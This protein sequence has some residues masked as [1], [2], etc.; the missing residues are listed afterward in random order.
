MRLDDSASPRAVVQSRQV[1]S[2]RGLPLDRPDGGP[3]PVFGIVH[4]GRVEYRLATAAYVGRRARI[5]YVVPPLIPGLRSPTGLRVEW[6]TQGLFS[7]GTARAGERVLVWTGMVREPFMTEAFDLTLQVRLS[8]LAL[9][10]NAPLAFES[11][12]EIETLP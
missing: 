3:P 10:A 7:N 6:R 8:E 4:F 11:Y 5:H 9:R 2:E 1:L 12:F